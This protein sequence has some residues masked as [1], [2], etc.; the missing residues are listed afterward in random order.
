MLSTRSAIAYRERCIIENPPLT[1][2]AVLRSVLTVDIAMALEEIERSRDQ[3]G[4]REALAALALAGEPEILLA[5][6]RILGHFPDTPGIA[7][8]VLPLM[9]E[10]PYLEVQS[11]AAELLYVNPDPTL[12]AL[13]GYWR[14]NHSQLQAENEYQEYPDF[15]PQYADMGFPD[16]GDAE[17]FSPADSDRAVGWWTRDDMAKVSGWISEELGVEGLDLQQWFERMQAESTAAFSIDQGKLDR[18][19]QL[20]DEYLKTQ[21]PALLEKIQQLQEE[22]SAPV[23]DAKAAEE[24]GVEQQSLNLP[25]A[26]GVTEEARFFI[27]EEKAGH[28][29]RLVIVYPLEGLGHTVIQHVWNLGDY[30][31]G[32]PQNTEGT[33]QP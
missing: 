27:A 4:S 32:W 9:L 14:D 25:G 20:T 6:M 10:S 17:W 33:D 28:V 16:Y 1:E 23:D 24:L 13:G 7:E 19:Q 11:T 21:N 12:A 30:P 26:A 3:R 15:A 5:A 8:K 18:I 2:C 31:G 22:I 29:A